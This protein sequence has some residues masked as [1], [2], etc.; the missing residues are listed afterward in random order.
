MN[1]GQDNKEPQYMDITDKAHPKV[2]LQD[3]PAYSITSEHQVE[4]QDN[5]AYHTSSKLHVKM[6]LISFLVTRTP[7]VN[8][9][10]MQM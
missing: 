4:L 5:P 7:T 3:N 10:N 1:D 9:N 2:T 8:K 6:Q